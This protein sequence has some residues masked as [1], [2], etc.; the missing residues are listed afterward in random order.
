MRAVWPL[1]LILCVVFVGCGGAGRTDRRSMPTPEAAKADKEEQ[2]KGE[3]DDD[4]TVALVETLIESRSYDSAVPML[5]RALLRRPNDP[6]LHT[7]MGTV[8][9]DKGVLNKAEAEFKLALHLNPKDALALA[10]LGVLYDL[11]GDHAAAKEAHTQAI[12]LAP[13]SARLQNNLGFSCFLAG[14][15]PAAISA[16]EEAISLDPSASHVYINLGF[17][18]TRQGKDHEALRIFRQALDEAAALNNL[19]MGQELRGAD[20]D[21]QESY[22][23]ALE[24]NPRLSEAHKNL[25]RLSAR[26]RA[27]Q[28]QPVQDQRLIQDQRQEAL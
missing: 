16:Y 14:D 24:I 17:A 5:K 28:G 23:R 13:L 15:T 10:G 12:A 26:R 27:A 2:D 21:A 11:R 1:L 22:M 25:E 18:L 6:R 9:R 4:L 8:L 3:I 7:L 20:E 19:A